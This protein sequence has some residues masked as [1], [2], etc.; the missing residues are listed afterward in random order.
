MTPAAAPRSWN[1]R[2]KCRDDN[3]RW[4]MRC[5]AWERAC[6]ASFEGGRAAAHPELYRRGGTDPVTRNGSG[7]AIE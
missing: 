7:L 1:W 2:S 5:P 4:I 6:S 3:C